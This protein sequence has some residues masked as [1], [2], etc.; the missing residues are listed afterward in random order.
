VHLQ[1]R[2]SIKQVDLQ[3]GDGPGF[4]KHCDLHA[5][6]KEIQRVSVGLIERHRNIDIAEIG[7]RVLNT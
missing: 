6:H 4:P 7:R 3:V 5:R 1:R 2:Q